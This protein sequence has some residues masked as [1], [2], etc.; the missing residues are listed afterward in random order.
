MVSREVPLAC[1]VLAQEAGLVYGKAVCG[2]RGN[3]ASQAHMACLHASRAALFCAMVMALVSGL[4]TQEDLEDAVL[5][6][7]FLPSVK[8]GHHPQPRQ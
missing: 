6:L 7:S 2:S 4:W 3:S 5:R 8:C 1:W